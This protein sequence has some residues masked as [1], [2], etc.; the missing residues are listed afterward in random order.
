MLIVSQVYDPLIID[1]TLF[2]MDI[3]QLLTK[4]SSNSNDKHSNSKEILPE[5]STRRSCSFRFKVIGSHMIVNFPNKRDFKEYC[6]HHLNKEEKKIKVAAF[7]MDDT[8]ITTRSGIKFGRGP[9]DWMWRTDTINQVLEQK[10]VKEN[11]V[12]VIFTNQASISVTERTITTSKSYKNF[13]IKLTEILTA[14][15]KNFKDTQFFVLAASGRPGKSQVLRSSEEE[16]FNTRKPRTGMWEEF[17]LY[18]KD[19]LG[20]EYSIDMEKSF[21]VGDAAGRDGDHLADD[22]NFAKNVGLQFQIPEDFFGK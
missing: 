18:V 12:V 9:H 4:T 1:T 14:L 8:L 16:H 20:D 6:H 17:E 22:L 3:A 19:T 21:Y 11:F 2:I 13:T 10:V 5:S 15:G 7:D